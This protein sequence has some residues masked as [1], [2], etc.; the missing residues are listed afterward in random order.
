MESKGNKMIL[1]EVFANERYKV[2]KEL[3]D[4]VLKYKDEKYATITQQE[5]ADVCKFSKTK[6]NRI[7]RELIAAGCVVNYKNKKNKYQI[8]ETGKAVLKIFNKEL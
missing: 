4:R 1:S 7:V 5:L 2:L 3:N 6:S 8:T